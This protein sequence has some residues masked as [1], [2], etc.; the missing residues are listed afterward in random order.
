MYELLDISRVT[1]EARCHRLYDILY[2][3]LGGVFSIGIQT[4]GHR[5]K[6]RRGH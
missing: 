6:R 4:S 5:W 2:D 3:L 1:L